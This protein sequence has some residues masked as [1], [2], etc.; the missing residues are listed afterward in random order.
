MAEDPAEAAAAAARHCGWECG[1]VTVG[2]KQTGSG[3]RRRAAKATAAHRHAARREG[4]KP[5]PA[6]TKEGGGQ[7][8]L[9]V[10][11]PEGIYGEARRMG[12]A[13]AYAALL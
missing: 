12:V 4:K 10:H 9:G 3:G 1:V 6:G 7:R 2:G 13:G 5:R 8:A 11:G